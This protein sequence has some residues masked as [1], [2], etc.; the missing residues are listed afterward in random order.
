MRIRASWI[1]VLAAIIAVA[2]P[3]TALGGAHV[4]ASH[5]VV[6]KNLAFTPRTLSIHQGDSVTWRWE[7]GSTPHNVT[8]SSFHGA[9]ARTHGTFTVRFAHKGTFNY[10]CTIHSF[11]KARIVVH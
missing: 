11:M 4:A 10:R 7:D 6:L 5:T 2:A 3:A 1:A 8:S 9:S